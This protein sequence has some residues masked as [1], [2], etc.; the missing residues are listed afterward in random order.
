M[1]TNHIPTASSRL[2]TARVLASL[3]PIFLLTG[4]CMRTSIVKLSPEQYPPVIPDSVRVFLSPDDIRGEYE[5]IAIVDAYEEGQCTGSW[6]IKRESFLR[7]LRKKAGELGA[8]GLI[9][10]YEGLPGVEAMGR[11]D[12][13][14]LRAVA[15]RTLNTDVVSIDVVML[16]P[17]RYAPVPAES[18]RV[19]LGAWDAPDQCD[20][21]A[22]I[23]SYE[24]TKCSLGGC[25]RQSDI[26]EELKR[27]AGEIGA[28]GIIIEGG[29]AELGEVHRGE[30]AARVIAIRYRH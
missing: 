20:Q 1:P 23:D 4:A 26:I 11:G 9:L 7:E 5:Q 16:T 21:I 14:G 17:Q 22:L 10:D 18:V 30:T 27:H 29:L 6:C 2:R 8:N 3:V 12:V 28:N 13:P 24:V 19:F 15:V 25:P